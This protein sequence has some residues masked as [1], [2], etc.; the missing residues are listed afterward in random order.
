MKQTRLGNRHFGMGRSVRLE[1]ELCII[2]K[3]GKPTRK[4][5]N[6]RSTFEAPVGRHSEKPEAFYE[7]VERFSDGPY[8]ELFA[9]RQRPGWTCFGDELV[10]DRAI[11]ARP[12]AL[13][14]TSTEVSTKH[15]SAA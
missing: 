5:K 2:G 9:R 8:C 6:V 10:H 13:T 11:S 15:Y 3:R 1:H 14:E 4:A 7:L 12:F